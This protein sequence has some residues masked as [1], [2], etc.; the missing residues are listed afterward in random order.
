[1]KKP[2]TE[3]RGL[4]LYH[5]KTKPEFKF[6]LEAWK[7]STLPSDNN[8]DQLITPDNLT[9][10]IT[11][12][13][14][15]FA[16]KNKDENIS[17]YVAGE[18]MGLPQGFLLLQKYESLDVF[19][20]FQ[21]LEIDNFVAFASNSIFSQYVGKTPIVSVWVQSVFNRL[22]LATKLLTLAKQLPY[23][24]LIGN[25]DY[26]SDDHPK[27]LMKACNFKD[28][29]GAKKIHGFYNSNWEMFKE[30]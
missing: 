8:S 26:V 15:A 23:E 20:S 12:D 24:L 22:P 11:P 30:K 14:I 28:L 6:V 13:I 17:I 27:S 19:F 18:E 7:E 5:I 3:Y 10:I 9:D 4:K 21:A 16:M 29:Y 25:R 2:V 1:M